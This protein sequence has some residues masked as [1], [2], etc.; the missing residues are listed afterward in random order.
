M[1]SPGRDFDC[2]ECVD[3]APYVLG[4]LE[5][6]ETYC[7]HLAECAIC[8]AAVV[9]L[10]SVVDTLPTTVPPVFAPEALRE[11]VIATVRSEAELLRAASDRADA[12][13]KPASRWRSRRTS[14][15]A[16]SVA[17][18]ASV[19]AGAAIALSVRSST[20]ERVTPAQIAATVGGA[21][22]SLRQIGD[23][24]ELAISGMPQPPLG[25]IYEVW[26]NRGARSPQPTN[27]LF[28]VTSRGTGSVDVPDSLHS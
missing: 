11:R 25:R 18:A 20:P 16:A 3:A 7:E 14:F 17:I 24:A 28:S 2:E 10:G 8:R 13:P 4:A 22:A 9:E 26:L 21:H 1:S 19:A 5:D 23:R 12:P 6:P 27:T 15:L